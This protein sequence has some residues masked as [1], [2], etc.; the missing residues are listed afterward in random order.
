MHKQIAVIGSGEDSLELILRAFNVGTEIAKRGY[1]LSTGCVSNS[2]YH[3]ARGA[4][5][6]GGLTMGYSPAADFE[7]HK[8][9]FPKLPL[10]F[11]DIVVFTD[12]GLEGR[13]DMLVKNGQ[14]IIVIGG[15]WGTL[16]ELTIAYKRKKYIGL[17]K[18]SGG[19]ADNLEEVQKLFTRR[20]PESI[21]YE[22]YPEIL[23]RELTE[24]FPEMD[25]K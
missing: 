9:R 15:D 19:M 20:S 18:G 14:Y 2:P 17:L 8:E 13:S 5:G 24:G 1:V 3:A 4:K 7:D 25:K 6:A 21:I 11:L 16:R 10:D 12:N 22:L 23:V